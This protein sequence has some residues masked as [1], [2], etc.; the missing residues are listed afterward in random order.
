LSLRT[1]TVRPLAVGAISARTVAP[2]AIAVRTIIAGAV[3]VRAMTVRTV[4]GTMM[5][6]IRPLLARRLVA[7]VGLHPLVV[8][9]LARSRPEKPFV[10]DD[11]WTI[12]GSLDATE[13]DETDE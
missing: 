9:L 5:L 6:A 7:I 1:I 8:A 2:W 13:E 10:L 11:L 4:A 12:E 3:A